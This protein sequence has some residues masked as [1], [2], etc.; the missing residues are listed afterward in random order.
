MGEQEGEH[1]PLLQGIDQA[2]GLGFL[3]QPWGD[4]DEP[5]KR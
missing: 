3:P 1:V 2:A 4:A 5:T